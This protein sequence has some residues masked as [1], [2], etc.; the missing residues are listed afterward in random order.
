MAQICMDATSIC[1][2]VSASALYS[3]SCEVRVRVG[4]RARDR[5]WLAV[6]VPRWLP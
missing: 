1:R 5:A 2:F 6:E 4:V 3:L